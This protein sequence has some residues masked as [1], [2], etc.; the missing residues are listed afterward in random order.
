MS[1]E[2]MGN[3]VFFIT[4][5][6]W[7]IYVVQ[8]SFITGSSALNMV[9]S[10]D[11]GERKQVQVATGIHWD[12]IEVWLI[13]ALTLTLAAFP[14][15]FAMIFEFLYVPL[16]L[17]LYALIARGVSIEVLYKL[18]SKKWVK[19]MVYAWTIS[20]ILIILILGVYLTNLFYGFPYDGSEF[21]S[22]FS[23]I[24]NVTTIT[25][26]LF[27]V[28]CSFLAGA[29]WISLTT[30]GELG[31]RALTFVRKSGVMF[32]GV[33]FLAI[34][35]MGLNNYDASIFAGKLFTEH[36]IFFALPLFAFLSAIAT[37]QAAYKKNGKRLFIFALLTVAFFMLTGFIGSFPYLLSSRIAFENGISVTEAMARSNSLSVIL[38]AVAIFYPV[39]IFYQSWKYKKFAKKV[40]YNDEVGE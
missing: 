2:V 22:N 18:D 8:E 27:F 9:V 6:T 21:T 24:F 4:M 23:S 16:F 32:G 35:L 31:D 34:T 14:L 30:N 7:I 39:I 1:N 26:G 37:L 29:G 13:A 20:S 38:I 36:H 12:G 17:L 25:G 40:N 10:K 19:A 3:I 11:E 28:S 15:V 5:F 33:V